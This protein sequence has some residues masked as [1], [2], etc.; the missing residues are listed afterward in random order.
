MPLQNLEQVRATHALD[1]A[2]RVGEGKVIASGKEGG[3]AMRKI[4]SMIMANGLLA[5]LAFAIEEKKDKDSGQLVPRSKGHRA[6]FDAIAQHLASAEIDIT[7]GVTDAKSLINHL[8]GQGSHTLKL[9]T[10]EALAW[11]GYARRFVSSGEGEGG[12]PEEDVQ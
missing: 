6:I 3:D 2:K 5:T 10:D 7:R 1:F 12:E 4:P 9:A 8:A 11:L